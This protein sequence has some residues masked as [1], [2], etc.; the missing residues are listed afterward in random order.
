MINSSSQSTTTGW[1][2]L[3]TGI[4]NILSAVLIILFYTV[5]GPFG[6]LNDIS[7]RVA[8]ILS[9]ILAWMLFSIF[10]FRS[11]LSRLTLFF[12]AIGAI[13]IVIG[14]ILIIFD[15]TGWVLAGWYTTVGN[16]LIGL[17]MLVFNNLTQQSN[18]LPSKLTRFGRVV[19]AIMSVGVLAIPGIVMGLDSMESTPWYVSI[20]FLGF[21]GTYALYP[22]WTLWLG[23]TLLSR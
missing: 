19:G 3:A 9:G 8:G 15:F 12:A 20:G 23:R 21:I 4:A 2:A 6:T 14:S 18:A 10:H 22:L 17:W 7:N 16:A 5:G 13:V 11:S 1:M